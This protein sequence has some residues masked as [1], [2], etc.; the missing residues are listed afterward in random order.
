MRLGAEGFQAFLPFG[1]VGC[2]FQHFLP[3]AQGAGEI[4]ALF[5]D[6]GQGFERAEVAGLAGEDFLEVDQGAAV[7]AEAGAGDR[8]AVVGLEIGGVDDRRGGRRSTTPMAH[9]WRMRG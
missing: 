8:S 2:E 7:V 3:G 4:L 5:G 1:H 6:V 9:P